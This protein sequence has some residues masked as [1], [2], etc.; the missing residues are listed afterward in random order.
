MRFAWQDPPED[1]AV[2]VV[3]R[4]LHAR[5]LWAE[6]DDF[7]APS[8]RHLHDPSALGDMDRACERLLLAARAGERIVVY[9]DYDA[10]GV[11]ACS[12]LVRALLALVPQ[13][14][15]STYVPH[16]LDEGY[17]LNPAAVAALADDGARVIVS[18]DCGITAFE[19]ALEARRRGIDLI[20][21]DHHAPRPGEL[22]DAFAIVHP[23]L[24]G[25]SYPFPDLSGAGVA[26]KVAWRLGTM[27]FGRE[28]VAEDYRRVLMD[29]LAPAALG[30][31]ADVVPLRGENRTI[32][33]F[34]LARMTSTSLVGLNALAAASGLAS[35]NLRAE[36]VGFRLA[37]RL[38]ACGRLAHAREAIEL[39]TTDNPERARAIARFLCEQNEARR[40]IEGEIL[41]QAAQDAAPFVDRAEP[42]L[43]LAREG[44]H[45]G[46]VGIVCSR[47]VERFARPV[48]LLQ[49]G[50]DGYH[51]SG[52]SVEGFNL[53]DALHAC[54][55]TL[56]SYGGH[57]MA[58][59]LRV[60]PHRFESFREAFLAEAG[61]RMSGRA[62][63]HTLRPDTRSSL[64][65]LTPGAGED[66]ERLGPFGRSN[67]R[68]ILRIDDAALDEAPAP[69]GTTGRHA[70]LML[71]QGGA[72]IRVVA[73]GWLDDLRGLRR[74]MRVDA[75]VT[76]T[77]SHWNGSR[78]MEAEL[79]DLRVRGA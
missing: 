10:D 46:V 37:P 79:R 55:E 74:G 29:L 50:E 57:E 21:T 66:L 32:S 58:A 11:T 13:A 39:F 69:L 75:M 65:E 62:F 67:P 8:L 27:G 35:G 25:S 45:A 26:F 53:H 56:S 18:V 72:S 59:G 38:N 4:I 14:R 63:V 20:I 23:A 22:P 17:G 71:R 68:P 7:L 6:R 3:D 41:D 78:R 54:R 48:L 76:P 51:G 47:L 15:I 44:W 34:G 52:R 19:P 70:R 24:P 36:D 60:E 77:L 43:V 31:I 49:Q 73:W 64:A 5:G 2:R 61:R 9:A 40:R 1:S 28:Q 16:R 30:I 33:R 12:I 42:A